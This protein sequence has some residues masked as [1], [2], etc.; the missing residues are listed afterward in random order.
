MFAN[1]CELFLA[2]IALTVVGTLRTTL[3]VVV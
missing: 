2:T 3:A 1:K